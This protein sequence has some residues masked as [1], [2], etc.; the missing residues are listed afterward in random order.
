MT[1]ISLIFLS[2]FVAG[3]IGLSPQ[4][5]TGATFQP[6]PVKTRGLSPGGVKPAQAHRSDCKVSVSG[7]RNCNE[8]LPGSTGPHG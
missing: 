2:T 3:V 7:M 5:E 8:P 4:R 1:R 6:A